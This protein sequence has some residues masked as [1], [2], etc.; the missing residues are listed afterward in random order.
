MIRYIK[1]ILH[2]AIL[3]TAHSLINNSLIFLEIVQVH[4]W[5]MLDPNIEHK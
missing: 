1:I 2:T 3:H 5:A 4:E